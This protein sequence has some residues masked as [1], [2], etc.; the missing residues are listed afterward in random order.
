VTARA[1]A[2]LL[3][4]VAASTIAC[5]RGTKMLA[6]EHL[7]GAPARSYLGGTVRILYA[8]NTGAFLSL[9]AGAPEWLRRDVLSVFIGLSLLAIG[10]L[11]WRQRAHALASI[12][13]GLVWAGGLSNLFDRLRVGH[14]VDFVMLSA[15]PLRTGVFNVA[16]V[17]ITAGVL[18]VL[19]ARKPD[20]PRTETI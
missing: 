20:G 11:A 1:R 2:A 18:M 8:E 6:S 5:D 4:L 3:L 13:L 10:V 12:G 17:A 7:A 14:V 16:D 9:G 19:F 15:G